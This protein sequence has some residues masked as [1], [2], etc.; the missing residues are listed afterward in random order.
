MEFEEREKVF[1][2]NRKELMKQCRLRN[3]YLESWK[4]YKFIISLQKLQET[5]GECLQRSVLGSQTFG[6]YVQ[7]PSYD[8]SHSSS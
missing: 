3:Y 4:I 8:Q 6:E 2:E 7:V 1:M 5:S